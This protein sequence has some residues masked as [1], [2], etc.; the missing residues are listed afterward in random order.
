[1][2]LPLLSIKGKPKCAV[3]T[4]NGTKAKLKGKVDFP[5]EK[6]VNLGL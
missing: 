1:V 5:S 3:G 2:I 6:E 4:Q